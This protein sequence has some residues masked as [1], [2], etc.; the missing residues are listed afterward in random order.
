M[1]SASLITDTST[2]LVILFFQYI[3]GK[4]RVECQKEKIIAKN[5]YVE[6]WKA[7]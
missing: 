5:V 7:K 1:W 2:R 4:H 3:I 6:L